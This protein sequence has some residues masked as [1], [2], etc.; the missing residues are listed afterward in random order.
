MYLAGSCP[1]NIQKY[2][3]YFKLS[4]KHDFVIKKYDF[5]IN[6]KLGMSH[7]NE[8]IQKYDITLRLKLKRISFHTKLSLILEVHI[9]K[10]SSNMNFF[11]KYESF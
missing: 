10:T 5:F 1:E 6:L 3:F 4:L 8:F 2:D 7:K 9:Q 11:P